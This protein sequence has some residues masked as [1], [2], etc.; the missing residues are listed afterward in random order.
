MT[1][2]HKT[3]V[4]HTVRAI[5]INRSLSGINFQYSKLSSDQQFPKV[6][7]IEKSFSDFLP[8]LQF[9]KKLSLRSSIN[10][11]LRTSVSPPSVSQLQNVYNINNPLVISIG[12]PDLKQQYTSSLVG[13]LYFYQYTKGQSFL[14][15]YF[16]KKRMIISPILSTMHKMIQYL[17][18]LLHY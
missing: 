6:A 1:M 15:I 2:Q 14:R 4:Y 5:E 17:L 10:I 3:A 8:N 18:P 16:C 7:G 9:R 13:P 12:N 11:F